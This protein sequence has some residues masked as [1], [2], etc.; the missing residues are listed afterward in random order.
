MTV[1]DEYGL[2]LVVFSQFSVHKLIPRRDHRIA[3]E[4]LTPSEHRTILW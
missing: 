4:Y 3:D 1:N 2:F